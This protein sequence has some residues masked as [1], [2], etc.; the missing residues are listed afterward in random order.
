M[1]D[2]SYYYEESRKGATLAGDIAGL[3]VG[4]LF[5]VA[6]VLKVLGVL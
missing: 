2:L 4:I 6:V 1:G 5:V 3:V